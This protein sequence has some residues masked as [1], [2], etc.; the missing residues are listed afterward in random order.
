MAKTLFRIVLLFVAL[1]AA[2][3]QIDQNDPV[4]KH[5]LLF[6]QAISNGDTQKMEI[7]LRTPYVR[8]DEESPWGYWIEAACRD[9]LIEGDV[10]Q[11]SV[12]VTRRR[13]RSFCERHMCGWMKSHLGATG[14]K[15]PA[16]TT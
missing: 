8:V 10:G 11:P 1:H 2:M 5:Q 4:Q 6:Y 15:L 3:A 12:T 7:I 16:G 13:W 14:S 9:D